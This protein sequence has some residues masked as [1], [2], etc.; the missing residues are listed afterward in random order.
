M[1]VGGVIEPA[2]I[3]YETRSPDRV[4]SP[5]PLDTA[6]RVL[7]EHKRAGAETETIDIGTHGLRLVPVTPVH[8]ADER[9]I[10]RLAQWRA[11][12]MAVYPTQFRVTTE[13]TR[14]WLRDRVLGAR[15]RIMF[16]VVGDDPGDALAH[17]G[18]DH[19]AD[20]PERTVALS[21]VV[22]GERLPRGSI[23]A[24]LL[25]LLAWGHDSAGFASVWATP[26]SDNVRSV[27]ML[28]RAGLVCERTIPLRRCELGGAR[29]EYRPREP[30]DDAPPDRVHLL[31][32]R[33]LA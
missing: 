14:A 25:R 21:N 3:R 15:D 17:L 13:G 10:E 7:A 8:L 31:M 23:H 1:F 26:F 9:L 33:R 22:R 4:T 30:G 19:A 12:H 27:R 18:F 24:A 6:Y 2:P 5:R 28:R 20:G 32:R 11:L 29:V 16:L